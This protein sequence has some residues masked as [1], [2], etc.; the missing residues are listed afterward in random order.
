MMIKDQ[1]LAVER[2]RVEISCPPPPQAARYTPSLYRYTGRLDTKTKHS[3]RTQSADQRVFESQLTHKIVNLLF[4]DLFDH[5]K[6]TILYG[7]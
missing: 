6:L 1:S 7:S 2:G 5:L 4:D 3:Y